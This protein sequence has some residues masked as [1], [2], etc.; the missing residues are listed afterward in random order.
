MKGCLSLPFR[1]LFLALLVVGGFVAWS[2]R[3]EIRR[4]IHE[5]TAGSGP[6]DAIGRGEAARAPAVVRK[7]SRLGAAGSDSVVLAA[8]EVAHLLAAG[9]EARLPGALDSIEVRLDRNEVA[10]R[11]RLDTRRVPL[12]FGPLAGIV[13]ERERLEAAGPLVLRRI[14]LLEWEVTRVRV[15]GIPLPKDVIGRLLR[16]AGASSAEEPVLPIPVPPAVGGLRITPGG[17]V[18][19]AVT[20]AGGVR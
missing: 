13:N 14:G 5:W 7:L 18:L 11:A 17:L 8:A 12:S 20:P 16:G 3:D 15:R 9:A 2:Y 19:F 1:L 10:V 4:R 6:A